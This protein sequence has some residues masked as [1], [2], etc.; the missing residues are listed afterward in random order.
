MVSYTYL[1]ELFD[2]QKVFRLL[3]LFFKVSVLS[4]ENVDKEKRDIEKVA[5][6]FRNVRAVLTC[7]AFLAGHNEGQVDE[8]GVRRGGAVTLHR[9]GHGLQ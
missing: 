8:Y 9:A 4:L 5:F 3:K 6:C 2:V 1:L 7:L